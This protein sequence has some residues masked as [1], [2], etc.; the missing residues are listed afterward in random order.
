VNP[1]KEDLDL[2]V[3]LVKNLWKKMD[4]SLGDS[5]AKS[6]EEDLISW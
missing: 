1:W 2:L 5:A 6:L 4:R 3:I